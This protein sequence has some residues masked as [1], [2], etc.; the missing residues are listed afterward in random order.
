[1]PRDLDSLVTLP[2]VARKTANVVL[3][4]AYGIPSGFVVD[5]HVKRVTWRLGLTDE[6]EPEAIEPDLMR[7]FPRD[8]WVFLGHAAIWHGRR[9]CHA[10]H[11]R[12]DECALEPV[13]LKRGVEL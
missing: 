3:G 13:C 4:T 6:T 11:P 8:E 5:T 12:C 7:L 1:V 2:G 10:H 9:V